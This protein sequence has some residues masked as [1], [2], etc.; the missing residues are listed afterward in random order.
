[1]FKRVVSKLLLLTWL[2][3]HSQ[4]VIPLYEGNPPGALPVADRETI[5]KSTTGNGRS[6]LVNVTMPTLTVFVPKKI[7]TAGTALIIFPGGG[8]NCFSI[9]NGGYE[10]GK[11]L[12]E[13][14][15]LAI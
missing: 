1:M 2:T 6:F 4:K 7:N 14:S 12:A 15:I 9:E 3:C 5:L 10:A 13:S 8:Y 11:Q